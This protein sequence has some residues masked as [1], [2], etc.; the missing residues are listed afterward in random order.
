MTRRTILIALWATLM[1]PFG[2]LLLRSGADPDAQVAAT[3][4]WAMAW[5]ALAVVMT[6][7]A[8]IWPGLTRWLWLRRAVGLAAFAGSAVHLWCYVA[9][10]RGFAEPGGEWALI[11]AEALTPGIL[12]GW[13]ALTLLL[14]PAI[15]S[16]DAMMRRLRTAWK[17]VQRL[18]WPAAAVAIVHLAVVH[19]GFSTALAVAAVIGAVQAARFFPVRSTRKAI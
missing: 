18:A 19:D 4:Y 17:P 6:P 10:M 16:N 14:P 7:L 9:A 5:L 1:A 15:A 12:T 13:I 8:R 2:A 3:G 11:A